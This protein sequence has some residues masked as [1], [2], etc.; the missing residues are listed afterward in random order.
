MVLIGTTTH[1]RLNFIA[2]VEA[3][4]SESLSFHTR[5]DDCVCSLAT[6]NSISVSNLYFHDYYIHA[7]AMYSDLNVDV[8]TKRNDS[9]VCCLC[10]R[11]VASS[12]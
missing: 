12:A 10:Y 5:K 3:I 11:Q 2:V 6:V 8:K 1:L 4:N 7:L 9:P